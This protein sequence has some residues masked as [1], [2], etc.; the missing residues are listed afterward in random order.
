[1]PGHAR[2]VEWGSSELFQEPLADPANDGDGLAVADG[3]VARAV[4][5]GL[6]ALLKS[7]S[8]AAHEVLRE[9]GIKLFR[10]NGSAVRDQR[11]VIRHTLEPLALTRSKPPNAGSG[12]G[13]WLA[14]SG[15]VLTAIEAISLQCVRYF[16]SYADGYLATSIRMAA[17]VVHGA[18]RWGDLPGISAVILAGERQHRVFL[19]VVPAQGVCLLDADTWVLRAMHHKQRFSA[20]VI[21]VLVCC[22]RSGNNERLGFGIH[23]CPARMCAE[24]CCHF[25][26]FAVGASSERNQLPGGSF[27]SSESPSATRRSAS[28]SANGRVLPLAS[29]RRSIPAQAFALKKYLGG[30]ESVSSTCDNEHTAA[31]LGQAEILGV[32]DPPRDCSFGSIHTTSVR[33]FLP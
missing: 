5:S 23:P 30:I 26:L 28:K 14:A 25:S 16:A 27:V 20:F 21:A 1:M 8:A 32:Q 6:Q 13:D 4:G 18:Q 24:S 31:S 9:I 33:P 10:P 11:V 22:E 15:A 17:R 7:H 12:L 29:A 2:A 3:F 19:T